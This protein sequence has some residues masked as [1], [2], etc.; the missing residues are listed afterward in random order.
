M[1]AQKLKVACPV[2]GGLMIEYLP[3]LAKLYCL[4]ELMDKCIG[5]R[6][7]KPQTYGYPI[8]C[9]N[10]GSEAEVFMYMKLSVNT[11]NQE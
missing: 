10:C 6:V 9:E 1:E 8:K 3:P 4:Q 5:M 7:S 2:C 11:D